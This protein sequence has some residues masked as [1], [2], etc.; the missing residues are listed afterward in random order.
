MGRVFE[1]TQA[2]IFRVVAHGTTSYHNP[3]DAV[4]AANDPTSDVFYLE[5]HELELML[6]CRFRYQHVARAAH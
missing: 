2:L 1:L 6:G 5:P 3:A 4:A